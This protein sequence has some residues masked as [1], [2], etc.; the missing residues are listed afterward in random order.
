LVCEVPFTEW[1]KTGGIR[2][3]AFLGLR[4]DKRPEECRREVP[5]DLVVPAPPRSAEP[6]APAEVKI[7]IPKKVFW[8]D[9]GSTKGD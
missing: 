3:P 6:V 2:H 1:T 5:V 8:P 7:T 4:A 9:E